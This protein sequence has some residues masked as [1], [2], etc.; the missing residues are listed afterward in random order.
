LGQ[1]PAA[2]TDTDKIQVSVQHKAT[3]LALSNQEKKDVQGLAA[4]GIR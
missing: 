3:T 4:G 2:L 1:A